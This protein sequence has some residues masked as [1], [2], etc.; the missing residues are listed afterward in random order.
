M[1][2]VLLQ[3]RGGYSH[4]KNLNKNRFHPR[5]NILVIEGLVLLMELY[6]LGVWGTFLRFFESELLDMRGVYSPLQKYQLIL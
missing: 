6:L 4:H 5:G 2:I 3:R 1:T